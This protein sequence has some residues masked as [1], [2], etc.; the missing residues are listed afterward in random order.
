M[1]TW[2]IKIWNL[3]ITVSV[4]WI[5]YLDGNYNNMFFLIKKILTKLNNFKVSKAYNYNYIM[6]CII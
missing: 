1:W 5:D 2:C 3:L 6:N 4:F